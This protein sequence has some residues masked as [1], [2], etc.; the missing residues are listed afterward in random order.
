MPPRSQ[1][2]ERQRRLGTEL[3]KLRLAAGLPGDKAA[4]FINADRQRISNIEAGRVDV[5]RN[6]LYALLRAYGCPE[7]PLFDGLMAM[8]QERGNG[9]WDGYAGLMS[10]SALDLAELES[11]ASSVHVHEPLLVPGLLQTADYT[12]AV[13]ETSG[14]PAT[15][16]DSYVEFRLARQEVLGA[17]DGIEYHTVVHEG[18]L[19]TRAGSARTMRR[20][21]Q[22]LIEL[23]REP[24][25]TIQV[26]PFEAG[27]FSA[28]SRA[29]ALFGGAT[30]ELD[31]VR[32]EQ[33]VRN[34]ILHDDEHLRRYSALFERLTQLALA[35]VDPNARPESHEGRDSLSLI[36]HL[37]YAL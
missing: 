13:C 4:T 10:R 32:L 27:T 18:A 33:P 8:A 15:A 12:R 16:I 3:K 1:P 6:G 2:S 30:C 17:T 25:I 7:G 24:N 21:L 22:R 31:T 20:Q 5:P 28:F 34:V 26:F 14:D 23:A 37:L 29:F 11:G 36:Q 9:W 19:H 35:P